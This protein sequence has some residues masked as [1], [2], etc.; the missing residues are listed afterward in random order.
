MFSF[1]PI[2]IQM[3]DDVWGSFR[4]FVFTIIAMWV[5]GVH[6]FMFKRPQACY[7]LVQ[8]AKTIC[9]SDCRLIYLLFMFLILCVVG[10]NYS[11]LC[12]GVDD[13]LYEIPKIH[14][15]ENF[16]KC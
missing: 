11:R 14:P 5:H 1:A 9:M 2:V 16:L 6:Y 10:D 4:F 15:F 8:A 3:Y 7:N 12:G 13:R